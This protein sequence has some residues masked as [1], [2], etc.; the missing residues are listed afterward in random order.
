ME[1]AS[2]PKR[3]TRARA[4]AK[5]AATTSQPKPK[6][7]KVAV[8]T[9]KPTTKPTAKTT[10][11]A[12]K[13]TTATTASTTA[14]TAT[15]ASTARATSN[16]RKTRSDEDEEEPVQQQQ[17]TMNKPPARA[18]GRPKK[19]AADPAQ[20]NAS[21]PE[22]EPETETEESSTTKTRATRGR[23]KKAT[24]AEPAKSEPAKATRTRARKTATEDKTSAASSEPA[25]KVPRRRAATSVKEPQGTITT[26]C[27][28]NPTPGLKSAVSRPASRI[29]GILKKTVTFQEPEKENRVPGAVAKPKEKTVETATGMRAKPVRKPAA[30][31]RTTRASAR[32]AS[33]TTEEKNQK[34]PLSPKKDGHNIPLS[35]D[36]DSD[37]ELATLEKTPLKPLL[38]SPIK[39]PPRKVD[40]EPAPASNE[41]GQTADESSEPT[42]SSILTSPVRR[43][44]P[45]PWKDSMKSP[46]KRVDG[47][48]SL[49]LSAAKQDSQSVPSPSKATILQSPAKRPPMPIKALQPP[50]GADASEAKQSPLKM[51][52]LQSPAK[53]P[54]SPVKAQSLDDQPPRLLFTAKSSPI[55]AQAD[56]DIPQD[57]PE[58]SPQD[59]PQNAQEVPQDLPQDITAEV[60]ADV[61]KSESVANE[62]P[63][64]EEFNF[65]SSIQLEFPGRLSAVLPRHADPALKE[66]PRPSEDAVT[67]QQPPIQ[68]EQSTAVQTEASGKVEEQVDDAM[69]VDEL[70]TI[71][72][73]VPAPSP[74]KTTPPQSPSNGAGANQQAWGLRA[75][76]LN[77]DGISDS[78][79]ELAS[80]GK[81]AFKYQEDT[82]SSFSAL[83]ATPTPAGTRTPKNGLPSSAVKAASRAIRSVSKGS[84]LAFTPLATQLGEWK[85]TSPS[86]RSTGTPSQAPNP[87]K[88]GEEGDSLVE[89]E[90]FFDDEMKMRDEMEMDLEAALMQDIAASYDE[91]HLTN[92]DVEL[93]AEAHEMSLLDHA[94]IHD[95]PDGNR[96]DDSISDA[97]QEYG[98][99]NAVPIDP[100]LLNSTVGSRNSNAPPVTPVRPVPNRNFHTVSKVPLK[101]ADDSPS[102]TFNKRC[103]SASKL[104]PRRSLSHSKNATVTSFVP[105]KDSSEM[106]IDMEH[107]AGASEHPPVTPAKSDV[108]S[109]IGTPARTPRRDLNPAL[110]RGA[111][112][113]VDVHTSEGADASTVFVELLS[114]MGARC[115][116]SWPWNPNSNG[117]DANAG[118][119]STATSKIG[120]T[121]VVYKDGG[122][123]TMEKVRESNG[124]VQC[125]GVGWVLE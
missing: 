83:P 72:A 90:T 53:R 56:E 18:R 30:G 84:K 58:D 11:K 96:H 111:V 21:E 92:E 2:P 100:A 121:H 112:V 103:A 26:T 116:K 31:G 122:K 107:G 73:E 47:I 117:A 39:P 63:V 22:T 95:M 13:A 123:R 6:P 65:A 89:V 77:D 41:T 27:S 105:T 28:T 120:I 86:K 55:K 14:T 51:S 35:R 50:F 114:Q 79:D 85:A 106:D 37:D 68:A 32:S 42:T 102:R 24:A 109:A 45:S 5:E 52:L 78:E 3:M 76:D 62:V 19:A 124:V 97:S 113:F 104:P 25:K 9:T 34:S 125:V 8:T 70:E 74:T 67:G 29:N 20:G 88:E 17:S 33:T 119:P 69:E 23:T 4:A 98:D 91:A 93:A 60:T 7:T 80:S 10:T 12:T 40:P 81:M 61:T 44:P 1:A 75:K 57:V 46:A 87:P 36:A 115:V 59:V 99:E 110:L 43:I 71:D 101:A 94:G 48:P 108:W 15:V 49:I 54:S 82:A 64:A 38:K 16:K 118:D 66:K